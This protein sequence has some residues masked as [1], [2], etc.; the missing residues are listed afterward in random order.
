MPWR[1]HLSQYVFCIGK[2]YHWHVT[3]TIPTF[4][5]FPWNRRHEVAM[6]D[7]RPRNS[8]EENTLPIPTFFSSLTLSISMC[9][10]SPFS[11]V[12]FGACCRI[13]KGGHSGLL[14][15][16][17]ISTFWNSWNA[18]IRDSSGLRACEP[19]IRD[20]NWKKS[21]CYLWLLVIHY[22]DHLL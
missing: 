1:C 3:Y 5:P 16:T 21:K 10:Q 22:G 17:C 2:G 18:N 13:N 8:L 11:P 12:P 9:W 20:V 15:D 4:V 14:E 19:Q 6:A 7:K